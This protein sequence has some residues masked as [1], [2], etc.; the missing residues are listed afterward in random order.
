MYFDTASGLLIRD[1]IPAGDSKN[2]FDYSDFRAV[3]GIQEPFSIVSTIIMKNMKSNSIRSFIT[4]KSPN[5]HSISRQFLMNLCR[6]L[7]RF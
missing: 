4:R 3:D 5:P 2:T 1:E 6:I 7:P